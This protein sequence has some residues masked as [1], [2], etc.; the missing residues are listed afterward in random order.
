MDNSDK[1]RLEERIVAKVSKSILGKIDSFDRMRQRF[2]EARDKSKSKCNP[3]TS[4]QTK[5]RFIEYA[6][7]SFYYACLEKWEKGELK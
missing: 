5:D 2:W 7:E 6:F 1:R 3:P 4:N